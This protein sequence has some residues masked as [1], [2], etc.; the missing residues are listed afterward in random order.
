MHRQPAEAAVENADHPESLSITGPCDAIL[1][2]TPASMA[3]ARR[4]PSRTAYALELRLWIDSKPEAPDDDWYK[5]FGSF[6]IC[7]KGALPKTFLLSGQAA[8]GKAVSQSRGKPT[9]TQTFKRFPASFQPI[10]GINPRNPE[11]HPL[12][13]KQD[14]RGVA[15][16]FRLPA[17]ET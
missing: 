2:P 13:S 14:R 12:S 10:T 5:D 3:G 16:C 4:S 6:K 15:L 1:T 9:V 11:I 17:P 7:G 8:K